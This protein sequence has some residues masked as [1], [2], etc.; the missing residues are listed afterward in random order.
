MASLEGIGS[1]WQSA[2]TV[3]SLHRAYMRVV[4]EQHSLKAALHASERRC[5]DLLRVSQDADAQNAENERMQ[6]LAKEDQSRALDAAQKRIAELEDELRAARSSKADL[7]RWKQEH[8]AVEQESLDAL[9]GALDETSAEKAD[10]AVSLEKAAAHRSEM[11]QSLTELRAL[12]QS[13]LE[14]IDRIRGSAPTLLQGSLRRWCRTRMRA[15]WNSWSEHV[16]QA[17]RRDQVERLAELALRRLRRRSLAKSVLTW[18]AAAQEA[19]RCNNVRE[20]ILF[21]MHHRALATSV[22]THGAEMSRKHESMLALADKCV[23]QWQGDFLRLVLVQWRENAAA[24]RSFRRRHFF[25][26]WREKAVTQTRERRVMER[27]VSRILNRRM[28]SAFTSWNN[29][30]QSRLAYKAKVGRFLGRMRNAQLSRLFVHWA[31]FTQ[32]SIEKKKRAR[33]IMN[34]LRHDE[35]AARFHAWASEVASRREARINDTNT[36]R[37]EAN[38]LAKYSARWRNRAVAR[39]F[40]TW[41]EIASNRKFLRRFMQRMLRAVLQKELFSAFSRWRSILHEDITMRLSRLESALAASQRELAVFREQAGAELVN[42]AARTSREREMHIAHVIGLMRNRQLARVFSRFKTNVQVLVHQRKVLGGFVEKWRNRRA[43]QALL[44]WRSLVSRRRFLRKI[45]E[46]ALKSKAQ[47]L[48]SSGFRVWH[49]Y[50]SAGHLIH[51]LQEQVSELTAER[52]ALSTR[53]EADVHRFQAQRNDVCRRLAEKLST[54]S[55]AKIL[56]KSF[57]AIRANAERARHDRIILQ[58]FSQRW[59]NQTASRAFTAWAARAQENKR[60]RNIVQRFVAQMQRGNLAAAFRAWRAAAQERRANR[61]KVLMFFRRQEQQTFWRCFEMWKRHA[62]ESALVKERAQRVLLALTRDNLQNRFDQWALYVQDVKEAKEELYK[63]EQVVERV[64]GRMRKNAASRAFRTWYE[65]TSERRLRR[66]RVV[67]FVQRWRMQSVARAFDAWLENARDRQR[68]RALTRK[69]L[70]RLDSK[71]LFAA[72]RKW[73]SFAQRALAETMQAYADEVTSLRAQLGQAEWDREAIEASLGDQVRVLVAH[74]DRIRE[75]HADSVVWS[76][77][78]QLL[79]KVVQQWRTVAAETR[80]KRRLLAQ[81]VTRSVNALKSRAF[82]GWAFRAQ[83]RKRRRQ[84][85]FRS[86]QKA[87]ERTLARSFA[88][89]S[90]AVSARK[91]REQA[92]ERMVRT[93]RRLL[94]H[95]VARAWRKW[96]LLCGNVAADAL[97]TYSASMSSMRDRCVHA[98]IITWQKMAMA[99]AFTAWRTNA[100]GRKAQRRR[101][102]SFL[103]LLAAM[104]KWKQVTLTR[105][106]EAYHLQE[107]HGVMAAMQSGLVQIVCNAVIFPSLQAIGTDSLGEESQAHTTAILRNEPSLVDPSQRLVD[108]SF[109]ACGVVWGAVMQA[110]GSASHHLFTSDSLQ[111]FEVANDVLIQHDPQGTPARSFPAGS[112]LSAYTIR[113]GQTVA[114]ADASL[115]ARFNPEIDAPYLRMRAGLFSVK[116]QVIGIIQAS[117]T[118]RSCLGAEGCIPDEHYL[119]A[120]IGVL[121]VAAD[122]ISVLLQWA[123]AFAHRQ[124]QIEC[125]RDEADGLKHDLLAARRAKSDLKNHLDQMANESTF[126]TSHLAKRLRAA[127]RKIDQLQTRSA[128]V[129]RI[130]SDVKRLLNEYDSVVERSATAP[131]DPRDF[132]TSLPAASRETSSSRGHRTATATGRTD[133]ELEQLE[134]DQRALLESF[135]SLMH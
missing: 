32:S 60:N 108:G 90:A 77:R 96:L 50:A 119:D 25:T 31:S 128:S 19:R 105:Y 14:R 104:N 37:R 58:R 51:E 38:L 113:L 85:V 43:F 33:A 103:A 68:L 92:V 52:D 82:S 18:R 42:L 5:A 15:A 117:R 16:A 67:H 17:Q 102:A 135:P 75:K 100:D 109:S 53:Y 55:D 116:E 120:C 110:M 131:A 44:A 12:T 121:S 83:E 27:A 112:S 7:V 88:S 99:K 63:S 56:Q 134:A 91:M 98:S 47:V 65:Y 2:R 36:Q 130:E 3:T 21:R 124:D 80:R 93:A 54:A 72:F 22:V 123:R 126:S 29:N 11:E 9:R 115:D 64:V 95:R 107:R 28:A 13:H 57:A 35:L 66:E 84:L 73:A 78:N 86:V 101:V 133:I 71:M 76:W 97:E 24:A 45:L 30:V 46:S 111:V 127:Q 23:A 87:R 41:A 89:L 69:C 59:R 122:S 132:T 6:A 4:S 34:L 94:Q 61:A 79:L 39:V 125:L 129:A 70:V 26:L 49:R 81:F 118:S 62:R 10:M 74:R 8:L 114:V 48:M 20:S 106:A 40:S 1:N